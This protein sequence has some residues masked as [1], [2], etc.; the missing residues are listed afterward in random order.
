M[1]S[2]QLMMTVAAL[3]LASAAHATDLETLK[4]KVA[5]YAST[6]PEPY[7]SPCVCLDAGE[8]R[9][10][11]GALRYGVFYP[12]L[13]SRELHVWCQAG[14]FYYS[15]GSPGTT[16]NCATFALLAK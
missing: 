1:K 7:K 15:D 16:E 2:A 13:G 12:T 14:P 5:K 8:N 10:R 4:T 11:A 9:G 3:L 6:T